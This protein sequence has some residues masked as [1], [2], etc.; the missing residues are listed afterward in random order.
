MLVYG[1]NMPV[2]NPSKKTILTYLFDQKKKENVSICSALFALPFCLSIPLSFCQIPTQN[3][4]V[5]RN[6][7]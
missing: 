1:L 2:L 5:C 3:A 7:D 4:L 6:D